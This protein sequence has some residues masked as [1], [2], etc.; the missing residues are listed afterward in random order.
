MS[1]VAAD[2]G[3]GSAIAGEIKARCRRSRRSR[4]RSAKLAAAKKRLEE[5]GKEAKAKG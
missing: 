3:R 1:V 4:R 5:L 2:K